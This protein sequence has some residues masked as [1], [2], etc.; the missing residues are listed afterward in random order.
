MT[1]PEGISGQVRQLLEEELPRAEALA[2][3]SAIAQDAE[4]LGPL[5]SDV[6]AL[7]R[8]RHHA[9]GVALTLAATKAVAP[10]QDVR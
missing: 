3:S 4:T 7:S 5:G 1:A 2:R 8:L 6:L 10:A 9:R